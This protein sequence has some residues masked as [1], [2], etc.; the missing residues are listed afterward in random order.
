MLWILPTRDTVLLS[1]NNLSPTIPEATRSGKI[2]CDFWCWCWLCC[3]RW[4][5]R[6]SAKEWF[7]RPQNRHTKIWSS[8]YLSAVF[9]TRVNADPLIRNWVICLQFL[10]HYLYTLLICMS[11]FVSN[12]R[13]CSLVKIHH[14]LCTEKYKGVKNIKIVIIVRL[15]QQSDF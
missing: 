4:R 14:F 10:V 9:G 8:K 13:V 12:K 1:V 15:L 2:W 7:R 3:W 5:W 11:L 6:M